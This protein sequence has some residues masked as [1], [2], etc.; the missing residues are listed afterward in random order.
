[1]A[2]M[3]TTATRLVPTGSSLVMMGGVCTKVGFVMVIRTVTTALMN[4]TALV[5]LNVY[6]Q[7][8]KCLVSATSPLQKKGK[9]N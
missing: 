1:M 2:A 7:M 6:T 4:L 8:S 5:S 9:G 3:R